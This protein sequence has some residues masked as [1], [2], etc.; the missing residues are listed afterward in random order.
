MIN[1][2][3]KSGEIIY[4]EII[5]YPDG[6]FKIDL[7][8]SG[9]SQND[10]FRFTWKYEKEEE[11]LILIYLVKN[12]QERFPHADTELYLPYLPNARMD[13]IHNDYEVFTLKYFCQMINSLG[14]SRVTVLDVHSSVGAAL[15]D[16]CTNLSPE[17]YI[18]EA[19]KSSGFDFINDYIFFPDEGSCKRYSGLF[20]ECRHTGFGIKKRDW[21]TGKILGLDIAGDSPKDRNVFIVDDICSYG[22]TV[23]HSAKKLK[24]MGCKDIDVFFTHCENSIE[25]GEL[26]KGD[27]IH[28]IYTTNSLC[29]LNDTHKLF[30][31]DCL[32]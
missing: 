19:I 12:V 28:R 17:K 27:L 5:R 7:E 23:F 21:S 10:Y 6:T 14:F 25:K 13:R 29:T 16:R 9:V 31:L 4:P 20:P 8:L 3:L 11:M 32:K 22:G 1:L 30:I 26:L 2:M 15:L 24:S 18:R